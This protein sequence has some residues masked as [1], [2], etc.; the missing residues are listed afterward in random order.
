MFTKMFKNILSSVSE[1]V[2]IFS[3]N[4][5]FFC[6]LQVPADHCICCSFFVAFNPIPLMQCLGFMMAQI[7]KN[8][9][10]MQETQV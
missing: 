9:A 5:L 6:D 10:A 4:T 1:V 7:V 8:L 3:L 2:L